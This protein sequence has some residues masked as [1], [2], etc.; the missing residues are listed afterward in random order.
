MSLS[1]EWLGKEGI[2]DGKDPQR[3]GI[4][5]N[6]MKSITCLILMAESCSIEDKPSLAK[7]PADVP[8]PEHSFLAP[9]PGAGVN[10]CSN[11]AE[12]PHASLQVTAL[13]LPARCI[14][15]GFARG[16]YQR[17]AS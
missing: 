1:P 11:E 10:E 8:W 15:R 5:G 4:P 9:R 12:D 6:H 13:C 17:Q 14:P 7:G 3:Q 2:S 16:Y